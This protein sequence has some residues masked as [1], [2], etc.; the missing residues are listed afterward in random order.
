LRPCSTRGPHRHAEA[1]RAAWRRRAPGP[2]KA[3]LAAAFQASPTATLEALGAL[4][5]AAPAGD[6][7]TRGRLRLYEGYAV[8][9][10][11][12]PADAAV[13][14]ADAA[15]TLR[16]ARLPDEASSAS[17]ARV[18][19]LAAAG[20][21]PAALALARTLGRAMH[22]RRD[23]P[24]LVLAINHGNA[25][26]LAGDAEGAVARYDAAST[27]A[28]ALDDAPRAAVA[29]MNAGVA[30]VEAGE[31][32]AGAARL[33]E[34]VAAF[35]ALGLG[36]LEREAR[37]NAAWADVHAGRVGDGFR[38]L[39]ALARAHHD[40]GLP[41]WEAVC[42]MDLADALR[43]A[44]DAPSAERE[45]L[46]AAARFADAGAV[47]E[48]AVALWMAA[49]AAGD[50]DARRGL[51][52]ARTA[53]R[54]AAATHREAPHA[55]RRPA[56]ADAGARCGWPPAPA[57]ARLGARARPRAPWVAADVALPRA[58]SPSTP[59]V[60]RLRAKAFDEARASGLAS[61]AVWRGRGPGR[62]RRPH[63]EG[64]R[65][66]PRAAAPR[67]AVRRG[68][69]RGPAWCV[70]AGPVRCGPPRPVARA[71]GPAAGA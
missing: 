16:A 1:R 39:D 44:G 6:P 32:D 35:H 67:G 9:R 10:A 22:G 51:A 41:R 62:A 45:A 14:Y 23:R 52:H 47:A 37:A 57:L 49:A 28:T 21:V 40:G 15:R 18:D 27:L 58:R 31:V 42:R 53:R 65:V 36:E 70:A 59:A 11:G 20:R 4:R 38:A 54:A 69:A 55:A 50:V 29:A 17:L 66:G 64:L 68:G 34:A 43:R 25:L 8:H 46:A 48:R 5:A 61:F 19:A 63:A 3:G 7:A 71:R 56:V 60:P 12:R 2:R 33:A 26:R 13:A 24:A 30:R